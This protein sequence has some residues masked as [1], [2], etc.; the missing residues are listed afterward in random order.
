MALKSHDTTASLKSADR[1]SDAMR[2]LSGRPSAAGRRDVVMPRRA[3]NPPVLSAPRRSPARPL[4]ATPQR[5]AGATQAERRR[6]SVLVLLGLALLTLGLG[7]LGSGLLLVAHV[8]TDLLLVGFLFH[9]RRQAVLKAQRRV[10]SLHAAAPAASRAPRIPGIPDRMPARPAPLA[11]PAP[12]PAARY[13][14]AATGTEGGG[15]AWDP[16]P[17]PP[18]TYVGKPVAPPR[19]HRVLDLTKPGEWTA[20]LEAE[21]A[22]LDIFDD[23]SGLE[24][25]LERRR[26]VNDW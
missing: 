21:D 25:I 1:F 26:A 2:V 4:P 6:R 23:E 14:D 15:S 13:D 9:C 11:M 7:M 18:P 17:V 8:I 24:E 3:P 19:R 22:G 16:V 10:R 20:A 5:P 12:V